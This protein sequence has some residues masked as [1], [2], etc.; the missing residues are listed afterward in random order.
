MSDYDRG[1]R[2]VREVFQQEIG[3]MLTD[4]RCIKIAH[5][6]RS[7]FVRGNQAVSDTKC[8]ILKWI[9]A[10]I[11]DTWQPFPERDGPCPCGCVA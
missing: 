10:N 2:L 4:Y 3:V 5:A 1:L 9:G 7:P 8:N 11:E 6:M